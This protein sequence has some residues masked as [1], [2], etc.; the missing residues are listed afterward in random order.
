MRIVKRRKNSKGFDYF[1]E[2]DT[3]ASGNSY[4]ACRKFSI[5][6]KQ[7][8]STTVLSPKVES[9]SRDVTILKSELLYNSESN[10]YGIMVRGMA[11]FNGAS[12][13][14]VID[15]DKRLISSHYLFG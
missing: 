1:V 3:D 14:S 15:D 5:K 11:H 6:R 13:V 7:E 12:S 2:D 8:A 10:M 9:L 4:I